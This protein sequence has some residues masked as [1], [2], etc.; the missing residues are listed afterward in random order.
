MASG[1][2]GAKVIHQRIKLAELKASP[3]AAQA[4][5]SNGPGKYILTSA[6][7]GKDWGIGTIWQLT[8]G[9]D[10][11]ALARVVDDLAPEA[12]SR[13]IPIAAQPAKMAVKTASLN[14]PVAD[15]S[16]RL[17]SGISM[18][19]STTDAQLSPIVLGWKADGWNGVGIVKKAAIEHANGRLNNDEYNG[20]VRNAAELTKKAEEF[21]NIE[22]GELFEGAPQSE[23]GPCMCGCEAEAHEADMAQVEGL[24]ACN[25]CAGVCEAYQ[26]AEP[27][28]PVMTE[29]APLHMGSVS[30]A[31]KSLAAYKPKGMGWTRFASMLTGLMRV[32]DAAQVK[33]S[34]AKPKAVSQPEAKKEEKTE[35]K[36][37]A[38]GEKP[39]W[40]STR[41]KEMAEKGKGTKRT[42]MNA[43]E[44]AEKVDGKE[45]ED[46]EKVDLEKKKP[47]NAPKTAKGNAGCD[48]CGVNDRVEGSKLCAACKKEEK[49]AAACD[50]DYCEGAGSVDAEGNPTKKTGAG[51]FPCPECN[52]KKAAIAEEFDKKAGKWCECDN[53]KEGPACSGCKAV[54]E[55]EGRGDSHTHCTNCKGLVAVNAG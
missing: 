10:G 22:G 5:V 52:A 36:A 50:C 19:N 42:L 55:R 30:Q 32:A 7:A 12:S 33:P 25:G 35:E 1:N 16:E 13:I 14:S 54:E 6:V 9:E 39:S 20:I 41:T 4:F 28:S 34:E 24:G 45:L 2:V 26:P 49:T 27:L 3:E 53:S 21:A 11:P 8:E 37:E 18:G 44:A 47:V 38:W 48:K 51:A 15:S 40:L 29:D 23:K 43:K 46:H 31:I 17:A